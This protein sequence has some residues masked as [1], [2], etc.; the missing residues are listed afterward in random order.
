M[1]Y[2][3]AAV[4]FLNSLPLIDGLVD[5]GDP[6]VELTL[7]LPSRLADE[8]ADGRADVAL[9][10]TVE[11]L[12][13]SSG[14]LLAPPA[15]I[16]CRGDVDSVKLFANG[17]IGQLERVRVDRG[18]RTSVALLR[19]LLAEIHGIRPEFVAEEPVPGRQPGPRE[20]VLVIGDR[21]FAYEKA[22]R[23]GASG[24]AE[25]MDLGGA[26]HDLTDSPFVFAAWAVAPD[27]IDRVGADGVALLG[28]LLDCAHREAFSRRH[29]IA[30]RESAAGR[31]GPGGEATA[32]A[33]TYYF[34]RS[35]HFGLTDADLGGMVG[36]REY[37]VKHGVLHADAPPLNIVR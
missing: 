3:V 13:G 17:A 22:F 31:L 21:C 27:L 29:E 34:E 23:A 30:S 36:F 5:G 2:R 16:A 19:I 15:G 11:I 18:S 8:L 33:I 4:S 7:A 28:D 35:L 1:V 10:P 24:E 6:R 37:C 14:G 9:L 32:T 12:D 20:A 26:W 25:T